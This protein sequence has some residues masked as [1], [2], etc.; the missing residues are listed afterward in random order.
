MNAKVRDR[1]QDLVVGKLGVP[2][3]NKNGE[4]LVEMCA[5]RGF[6]C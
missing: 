2:G 5:E 1:E 6:I 4:C 3:I